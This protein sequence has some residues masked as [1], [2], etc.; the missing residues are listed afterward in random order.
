MSKINPHHIELIAKRYGIIISHDQIRINLFRQA[1]THRSV[2]SKNYERLEYLGDSVFHLI[3]SEYLYKRYS[4][5]D[6]GFLTKLRIRLERSDSMVHLTKILGL[7]K[8]LS[9]DEPIENSHYEDIFEAFIAAF[10]LNFGINTTREF[11]V[12]LLE[13]HKDFAELIYDN[14]NYKDTLAR[15]FHQQVWGDPVYAREN[16]SI[17]IRDNVGN[18]LGSLTI[19]G[20]LK[21]IEQQT[22]KLVLDKLGIVD[23]DKIEDKCT[24]KVLSG[25]YNPNNKLLSITRIRKLYLQYDVRITDKIYPADIKLFT[26]AMTHGSYLR[27]KDKTPEDI[28]RAPTSVALQKRSNSRLVFLGSAVYHFLVAQHLFYQYVNENEGTLT[29][30][31]SCLESKRVKYQLSY[32]SGVIDYVLVSYGIESMYG[33]HNLSIFSKGFSAFLGV[34]YLLFG[35]FPTQQYLLKLISSEIDMEKAIAAE[36]NYKDLVTRAC[37]KRQINV[38]VYKSIGEIIPKQKITMGLYHNGKL[39][40]KGKSSTKKKASQLAAKQFYRKYLN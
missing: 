22:A 28:L 7:V 37:H 21:A 40:A 20:D 38:P 27:R 23:V 4:D 14:D 6:E 29:Q 11:I 36:T 9:I 25:I 33:R 16:G 2:S 34:S 13:K 12:K 32:K 5:D 17:V 30:L 39:L 24:E 19:D 15:Y 8:F 10:Y 18:V 31:R 26:E 3:V 35:L 1:V